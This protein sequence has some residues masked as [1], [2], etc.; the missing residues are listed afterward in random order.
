MRPT[1]IALRGL[2]CWKD[3]ELELGRLTAIQGPNGSGKTAIVQAVKLALLGYAPDVGRQL[4]AT[5]QLID[6]EL[7]LA[8]VGL[9]FDSGF[10]I[11]RV[12]GASS[13]TQVMPSKG[14][15]TGRACQARI[16]EET[17]GLLVSL[18]LATFL[19]LSDEKRREWLFEHLPAAEGV[20]DWKLFA[21]WTDAEESPLG[22]VVRTLWTQTVERAPHPVAGLSAAIEVAHRDRLEADR[23]RQAQAKVVERGDEELRSR[24][25]PEAVYPEELVEL[26]RTLASLNQRIGEARA[27]REAV[28]AI[29]ARIARTERKRE[30]LVGQIEAVDASLAAAKDVVSE[31]EFARDLGATREGLEEELLT[32]DAE[33][34]QIREDRAEAVERAGPLREAA[35]LVRGRRA[36]VERF[37][38]CP[39][40]ALGCDLDIGSERDRILE[41]LDDELERVLADCQLEVDTLARI[42]VELARVLE[43]R[44]R[45]EAELRAGE[46]VKAEE[47]KARDA[48]GTLAARRREL[49]ERIELVAEELVGA[50]DERETLKSDDGARELYDARD[51]AESERAALRAR[52]AAR[53]RHDTTVE[54]HEREKRRLETMAAKAEALKEL[55][56]NLLRLRGHVI[57]EMVG[58]LE[59]EAVALLARMDPAKTFRFVHE[60][61]GRAILDFGFEE[62]G[63]LRLYAAAS[64]GERVMLTVAFLGAVLSILAPPMRLLV[65][66]DVEQLDMERRRGLLGALTSMGEHWD[67]VIVAGACRLDIDIDSALAGAARWTVVDLAAPVAAVA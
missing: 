3:Y 24:D 49:E 32:N 19:E 34:A 47:A 18:D 44:E 63:K 50:R 25:V 48:V 52:E 59:A 31:L 57:A 11:R 30:E 27:G 6:E 1:T 40:A 64:K 37:G 61:E 56:G 38:A 45:I 43:E 41:E 28:E 35:A 7:G 17:G 65:I 8:E 2:K 46:S 14:E 62:D 54:S 66:D 23:Q 55:D 29:D 21:T 9:S 58:P 42:E 67:A 36:E 33:L 15:A 60:R 12:F 22:D 16:D 51:A 26:E 39:Y 10:G 5:R 53:I 4:Q 13:E 20:L